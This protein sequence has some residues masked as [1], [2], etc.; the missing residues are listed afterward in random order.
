MLGKHTTF[1]INGENLKF[2]L[3]GANGV[4]GFVAEKYLSAEK[5]SPKKVVAEASAE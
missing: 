3:I 5:V 1:E 2:V 4:E